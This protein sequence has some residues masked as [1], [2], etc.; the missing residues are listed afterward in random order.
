[1]ELEFGAVAERLEPENLKLLQFEQRELLRTKWPVINSQLAGCV[2]LP[3]RW[4]LPGRFP[5]VLD[6]RSTPYRAD[7]TPRPHPRLGRVGT[8]LSYCNGEI[9]RGS[10][11]ITLY[12]VWA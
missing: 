8:N 5:F 6:V 7:S 11:N 4:C 1:V 9:G 2:R 10:S 3:R 12:M